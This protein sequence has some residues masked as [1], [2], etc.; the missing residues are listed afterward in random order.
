MIDR[1]SK[2]AIEKE[3]L[4]QESVINREKNI[5]FLDIVT[6]KNT[7]KIKMII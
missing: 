3:L 1:G 4:N 6:F 7:P 2:N 5:L